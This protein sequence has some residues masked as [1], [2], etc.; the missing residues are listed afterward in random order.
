ME[1]RGHENPIYNRNLRRW[2][3]T[4]CTS[5]G[6]SEGSEA[7]WRTGV[8]HLCVPTGKFLASAAFARRGS[9]VVPRVVL[10][11]GG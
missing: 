5:A 2:H 3:D 4:A 7:C 10:A 6:T 8:R 11:A 1:G 9:S